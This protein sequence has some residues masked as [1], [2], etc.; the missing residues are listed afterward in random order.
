MFRSHSEGVEHRTGASKRTAGHLQETGTSPGEVTMNRI[1]A[2]R[3]GCLR[4]RYA[5]R[6]QSEWQEQRR[7]G[8]RPNSSM[9]H[10]S[11]TTEKS[12]EVTMKNNTGGHKGFLRFGKANGENLNGKNKE[13]WA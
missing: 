4:F 11:V 10:R 13:G 5:E 6:S 7:P 1:L 9:E 3:D 2:S 8:L 12:G